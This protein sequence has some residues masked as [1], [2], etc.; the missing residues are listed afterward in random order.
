MF[1]SDINIAPYSLV[2]IDFY[3]YFNG[4]NNGERLSFG[5]YNGTSWNTIESYV[6]GSGFNNNTFYN[7]TVVLTS[8]QYNFVSNSGFRFQCIASKK[9]E[10]IY[11]DQVTIT[12]KTNAAAKANNVVELYSLTSET[13][14]ST[15]EEFVLYPNPV[16][17]NAITVNILGLEFFSYQI[18][19]ISGQKLSHGTTEGNIDVSNLNSG[20][21]FIKIHDG[22]EIRVKKFIKQ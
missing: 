12:G 8:A 14:S 9:N 16:K 4:L 6:I 1:L 10:Q 5:Y 15:K 11:I 17:E 21:Y 3:F 20:I 7:A 22:K 2:E 19:N 13:I 18:L